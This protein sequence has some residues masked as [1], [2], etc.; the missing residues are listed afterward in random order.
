MTPD[1]LNKNLVT[2]GVAIEYILL[3]L[4]LLPFPK[5][6]PVLNTSFII[7]VGFLT[8][9]FM[10]GLGLG[11]TWAEKVTLF[12]VSSLMV[13]VVLLG[14]TLGY[15]YIQGL[16]YLGVSVG[17]NLT[18]IGVFLFGIV[19]ALIYGVFSLFALIKSFSLFPSAFGTNWDE[20]EMHTLFWETSE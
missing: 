9:V 10:T 11:N 5:W 13:L 1:W 12:A 19:L 6:E 4:I 3:F 2:I 15:S 18:F 14:A 20:I 7:A 8:I 16:H 17:L